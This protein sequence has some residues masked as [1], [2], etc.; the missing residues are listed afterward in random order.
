MEYFTRAW[1][2]GDLSDEASDR[3]VDDYNSY[4]A[5]L[6]KTAAVWR[7]G[8][9]V[10]LND[11]WIDRFAAVDGNVSLKLLTGDN[12]RGYWHT[13]LTYERARVLVGL[14]VLEQAVQQRPTEIWYDEFSGHSPEMVHRFLLVRPGGTESRGEVHI[15]FSGFRFSEVKAAGRA[16]PSP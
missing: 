3:I 11:A 6:D 12:Q 15:G 7:F 4:I 8:T 5:T 16:L 10:G 9:T 1:A 13:D 2:L 14:D